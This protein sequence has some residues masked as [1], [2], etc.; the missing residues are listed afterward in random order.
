MATKEFQS[1]RGGKVGVLQHTGSKRKDFIK[2]VS[3]PQRG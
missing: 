2:E 3:I 1:P